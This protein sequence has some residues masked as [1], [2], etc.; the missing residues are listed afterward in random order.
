VLE[1]TRSAREG[2][3]I[4][5]DGKAVGQV[6]SGAPAPTVG[7]P[8]AMAYVEPQAAAAG[9][10]VAIDVRGKAES[11]KVVP[12]PFYKRPRPPVH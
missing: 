5:L 11:A 10:K 7:K 2:C 12:L 6:T 3:R 1:G 9:T 4:L 8:V